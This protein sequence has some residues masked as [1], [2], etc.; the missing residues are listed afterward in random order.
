MCSFTLRAAAEARSVR[1]HR[2]LNQFTELL[3]KAA[4]EVRE[5][6]ATSAHAPKYGVDF[7]LTL[8]HDMEVAGAHDSDANVERA[9]DG[10]AH[11][12]IDCGPL[13]DLAPS[14]WEAVGALDRRRKRQRR[15]QGPHGMR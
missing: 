14:F 11:A 12:I 5:Y 4:A 7:L 9:L 10:L 15:K 3:Q 2:T 6:C 13:G 1:P 8:A